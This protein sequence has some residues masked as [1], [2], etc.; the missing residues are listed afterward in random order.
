MAIWYAAGF[1]VVFLTIPVKWKVYV[2]MA[3]T[4]IDMVTNRYKELLLS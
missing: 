2:A 3:T 4:I 1:A